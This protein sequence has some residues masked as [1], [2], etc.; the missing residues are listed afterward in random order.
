MISFNKF[1]PVFSGHPWESLAYRLIQVEGFAN[2]R[3]IQGN[4]D[5]ER[6]KYLS[7]DKLTSLTVSSLLV[8]KAK[9][10]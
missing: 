8:P 10:K 2:I 5:G 1:K 3:V 9:R 6:A 7:H 4:E